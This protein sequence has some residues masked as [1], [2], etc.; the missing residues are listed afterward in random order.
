MRVTPSAQTLAAS[1]S[2]LPFF[3][4]VMGLLTALLI[5]SLI[6]YAW[7]AREAHRHISKE[8]ARRIESEA[9]FRAT[10]DASPLGIFVTSP[11]GDCLYTNTAYQHITGLDL[12]ATLGQ[13]WV[14]AIHPDD[15]DRV[16]MA[17]YATAQ[18][19]LPYDVEMRY[20]QPD[21]TLVW[22][23][24]KAASMRDGDIALGYVGVVEDITARKLAEEALRQ[25]H[26]RTQMILESITDAFLTLDLEW[27]FIAINQEAERL[28]GRSR[29][30]LIGKN[31]WKEYPEAVESQWYIEYHRAVHENTAVAFEVFN[32]GAQRWSEA[33]AYPSPEGLSVY[34]RDVTERKHAEETLRRSEEFLQRMI[35][36]SGDCI[37]VLDMEGR[38]QSINEGGKCLM[39]IEDFTPLCGADWLSFWHAEDREKAAAA[40]DAAR[41]GE[42]GHLQGYCP[43]AKGTPKWWDVVVTPI[44]GAEGTPEQLLCVSRDMTRQK[45]N[46]EAVRQSEARLV[47]AQRITHTGSYD[48]NVETGESVW[49]EETYRLF[50]RDPALGSPG[51]EELMAAF[52]P[53]DA[54]RLAVAR[55]QAL[56]DGK[57]YECDLRII[58][59]PLRTG[60]S[61]PS[62]SA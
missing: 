60:I 57:S 8:V 18:N 20:Q 4:L 53:E 41:R 5:G 10:S 25:A 58:R 37:K 3:V 15:R 13:G 40:V 16:F 22:A 14:N 2:T 28:M 56:E 44:F 55:K 29:T 45:Q 39:E 38:L 6:Y 61:A 46:E 48:V 26:G 59:L 32:S 12:E 23:H 27:N 49:S 17:W 7:R 19:D 62:P 33:R 52:V 50:D 36:S 51:H 47:E 24:V 31:V 43:T 9:R 11:D 35:A 30:E 1:R 42:V 21:G 54:R 34:F